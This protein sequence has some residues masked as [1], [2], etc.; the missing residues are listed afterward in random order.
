M[1]LLSLNLQGVGGPLK[2]TSMRFLLDKTHPDVILFQE[3]LVPKQK[4][5]SYM[6]GLRP[7]WVVCALSSV[8]NSGGLMVAWDLESFD[9]VPYLSVGGILL[10]G[11]CIAT[12]S[13]LLI[14]NT[15]GPCTERRVF[16]K[17]VEDND[18]LLHENLI[19]AGDLNFTE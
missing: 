15:Y 3:T 9:L 12:K 16:W 6:R 13:E 7:S 1:I 10:T 18:I 14:L 11:Q 4:D 8:G 19:L 17:D 2:T 5:I